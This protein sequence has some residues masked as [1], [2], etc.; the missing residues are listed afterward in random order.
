MINLIGRAFR[1]WLGHQQDAVERS[2]QSFNRLNV[3]TKVGH[4]DPIVNRVTGRIGDEN[5]VG[6]QSNLRDST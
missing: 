2:A 4:D 3:A 6:L 5:S 1:S